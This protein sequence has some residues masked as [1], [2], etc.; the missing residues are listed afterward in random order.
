MPVTVT[1]Q[2]KQDIAL[3][4]VL[5]YLCV[6]LL[7]HCLDW[8]FLRSQLTAVYSVISCSTIQLL[9]SCKQLVHSCLQM[10]IAVNF[11]AVYNSYTDVL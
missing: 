1:K 5:F 11:T 10:F 8:V 7:K 4:Q 9:H 3:N 2:Q 6:H